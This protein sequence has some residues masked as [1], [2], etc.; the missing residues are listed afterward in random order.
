M[1]LLILVIYSNN[2]AYY[3]KMLEVQRSILHNYEN[4]DVYFIQSSFEHNENVWFENDMVYVRCNEDYNTILYKT[5]STMETLKNFHNR[6]YDFTI[7]T[8][9][10]TIIDVPKLIDLLNL[11]QDKTYLYAGDVCGVSKF[12]RT[13]RFALGTCIILSQSLANKM[14]DE[15]HKF[16]HTIEDDVAFGLFV[17][18]NIPEAFNH[19]LKLGPFV[20]Y[21][22]TLNNGW[23]SKLGDFESFANKNQLKYICYRNKTNSREEDSKIMEYICNNI[24][25]TR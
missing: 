4:V 7:R 21:T 15:L 18:D 17:E 25:R 8:N 5:L 23:D 14:I 10:S 12:N 1:K 13:I 24:I 16:N 22:H 6:K 20:F 11:F 3:D 2:Q 9:I 19:N